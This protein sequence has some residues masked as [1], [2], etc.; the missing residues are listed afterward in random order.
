MNQ[1]KSRGAM[2]PDVQ[3]QWEAALAEVDR[4]EI[5]ANFAKSEAAAAE[6][7]FSG[8]VRR[9]IHCGEKALTDLADEAHI[10]IERL[11]YFMRGEGPLDT[12]EIDRL[13]AAL[14][15]ELSVPVTSE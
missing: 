4:D 2:P 9:A 3:K 6:D 12:P 10:D 13:L 7:T 15:I 5:E 1:I 8:A 14:R 11:A